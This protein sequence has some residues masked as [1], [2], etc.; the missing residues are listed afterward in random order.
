MPIYEYHCLECNYEFE[1]LRKF[2][3]A[4]AEISCQK[5]LHSNVKRKI[6]MFC[7]TSNGKSIAGSGA[8]CTGCA[9]GHCTDCH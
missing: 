2:S 3:E 5:C 6:S 1:A 4:D 8:T 7:A 9:G